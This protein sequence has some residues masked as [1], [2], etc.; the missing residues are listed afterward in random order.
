M[1][2]AVMVFDAFLR[3][4]RTLLIVVVWLC[5]L[6]RKKVHPDSGNMYVSRSLNGAER[7]RERKRGRER[8]R[9]REREKQ[10]ET[11]RLRERERETDRQTERERERE[12]D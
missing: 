5:R 4:L 6:S 9:E 12:R 11:D 1:S 3:I 8:E 2:S 10:T 7:E